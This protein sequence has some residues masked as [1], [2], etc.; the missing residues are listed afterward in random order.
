MKAAVF[1]EVGQ[2]L[3][4]EDIAI[5]KPGPREVLVKTAA[6]G[7]CHS[8]LHF[9]EGLYPGQSPM[10]LGHE[11]AG[12]VEQVGSDVTYVQPG[13]HVITCLSVFCGH[14]ESCLTGHMSLCANPETRRGREDE[15]RLSKEGGVVHQFANLS[16]FAEQMLIHEHGLV[17]IREDMPLDRAAL[18]GCGVTT[19]VGS[20]FHTA[21]VEPGSTVAVIGCGGVGLSC[22]NGAALAGAGK[23]I[24]IDMV[25][26][27][28]EMSKDFGATHV[29]NGSAGDVVEQVREL[30]GGGVQ[31]SFEAIGLKDTAEQAF[32]MLRPGGTATV[33][34]M[35]PVGVKIELMGSAF[36]QE[37]K[38]QGSMMGSNRFRVDMPRFI[39]FYLQGK[40][41]LDQM[42]SKR[43][44]LEN[45]MDAFADMKT[46]EVARSVI[47]F[48]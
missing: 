43:I 31:Y 37:K 42:I 14:C 15:P 25:D 33:I 4:I 38:I 12:V 27:K 8:D 16:S 34:G 23:V 3:E 44:P 7:V 41:H 40:L 30:T 19:G 13:D 32:S 9:I 22:I 47:V 28:L 35:I 39:D 21:G 26:S 6:A 29:V 10:V 5:S 36:L 17:K 1:R 24:A 48:K 20:V 11:S 18:I 46:G 2:P 45:I